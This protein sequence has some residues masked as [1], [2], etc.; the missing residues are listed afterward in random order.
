MRLHKPFDQTLYDTHK[1]VELMVHDLINISKHTILKN[2]YPYKTDLIVQNNETQEIVGG[3]EVEHWT[4]WTFYHG[5]EWMEPWPFKDFHIWHRKKKYFERNNFLIGVSD[6]KQ[7]MI[8][9]PLTPEVE[10]KG[11]L[12]KM[13][14]AN[15]EK[16]ELYYSIPLSM[17][18]AETISGV[19]T[20]LTGYFNG[21][22]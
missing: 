13:Q 9:L 14:C 22:C 3:I 11:T 17:E 2:P 21:R 5:S 15:Y 18:L 12:K 20:Y 8:L 7:N 19:S 4:E 16:P 10:T 6:C 1:D